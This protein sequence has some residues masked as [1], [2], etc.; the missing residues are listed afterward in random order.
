MSA[1]FATVQPS[2]RAR[3]TLRSRARR[4]D[5]SSI[6]AR[7]GSATQQKGLGDLDTVKLTAA[8]GSTADVYLFGGV[9]TS[10]KPKGGDDVLYV[11]PD[12]KFDKVRRRRSDAR[13]ALGR[14]AKRRKTDRGVVNAIARRASRFLVVCRTAG[15]S[16][17][18]G[19]FKCT[20]SRATSTGRS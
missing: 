20:D 19:R 9:V 1:S 7:A 10:F 12:A 5:R 17:A 16:S 3:A 13:D 15:R 11:R 14:R 2:V 4:A 18:R 8:D 6:V